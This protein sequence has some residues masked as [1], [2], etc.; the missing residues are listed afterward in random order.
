VDAPSV[1]DPSTR[2]SSSPGKSRERMV[3][4]ELDAVTSRERA[5][6]LDDA[7]LMHRN[8]V[9]PLTNYFVGRLRRESG[10]GNTSV[11]FLGTAVVRDGSDSTLASMLPLRCLRRGSISTGSGGPIW[12]WPLPTS[13]HRRS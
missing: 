8:P 5:R 12:S 6:Y 9:E 4:G 3:G 11:G 13:A 1:D 2:R 7:G 10:G